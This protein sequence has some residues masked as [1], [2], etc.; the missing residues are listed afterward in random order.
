M[1]TDLEID[2]LISEFDIPGLIALLR[3]VAEEL[4]LRFM[5][6]EAEKNDRTN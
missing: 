3:R 6:S 5:E 2:E 4:E 1:K